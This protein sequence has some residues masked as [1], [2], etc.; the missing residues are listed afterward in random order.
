MSDATRSVPR[1]EV[2]AGAGRPFRFSLVFEGSRGLLMAWL[3][4]RWALGLGALL[5]SL[6]AG[7]GFLAH[8]LSGGAGPSREVFVF[9]GAGIGS[10]AVALRLRPRKVHFERRD[11]TW[12][13][14]ERWSPGRRGWA[15]I[16]EEE[17]LRLERE[18]LAGSAAAVESLTLQAGTARLLSYL[19]DPAI[20]RRLGAALRTA[21]VPVRTAVKRPS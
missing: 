12:W 3:G 18:S 14:R 10:L 8:A 16:T 2:A 7:T 19:G 17:P 9:L 4:G 6:F 5:V 11:D 1:T 21:G 13:W 20:A 15:P